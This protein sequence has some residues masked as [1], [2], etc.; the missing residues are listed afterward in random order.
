MTNFKR[1]NMIL[2]IIGYTAAAC[3]AALVVALVVGIAVTA[4]G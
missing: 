4:V 3:Y 2:D 1:D